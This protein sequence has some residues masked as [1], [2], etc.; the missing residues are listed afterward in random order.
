MIM[1]RVGRVRGVISKLAGQPS[2]ILHQNMLRS[3][4][5]IYDLEAS[6]SARNSWSSVRY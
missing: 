1:R 6:R 4:H 2:S 5:T 3:G